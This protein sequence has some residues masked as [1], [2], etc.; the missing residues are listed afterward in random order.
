MLRYVKAHFAR[1]LKWR[2]Q[3]EELVSNMNRN[4]LCVVL[5]AACLLLSACLPCLRAQ[6]SG[7]LMVGQMDTAT[8]RRG[9]EFT[10]KVPLHL[11]AGFHVNSNTPADEYLIPLRLTW[12]PGVVHAEQVTYP[13][14]QLENY[15]FSPKPVSVFSGTFVIETRFRVPAEAR[16]GSAKISG[17]LR[18]QACNNKECLPPKTIEVEAPVDVQ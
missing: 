14:P 15:S 6:G 10:L 2:V 4:L 17:K 16:P 12:A 3:A 11:K 5:P 9:S 13:K 7:A 18:Y 8:A 1:H